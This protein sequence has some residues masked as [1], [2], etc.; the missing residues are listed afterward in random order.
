MDPRKLQFLQAIVGID[1]AAALAKA[2]ER[3]VELEAAILPRV[4]MAWLEVMSNGY[5]G[6]V[7]GQESRFAFA[8]SEKG[9][10]GHI[11]VDEG[12]HQFKDASLFHLAGCVAAALGLDHER[13]SPMA[14]SEQL[15]KLGK[16]IDLLVKSRVVQEMAKTSWNVKARRR[17]Q[18][19]PGAD[20]PLTH[21]TGR[22]KN[23]TEA[24]VNA[25]REAYARSIGLNP[26][27]SDNNDIGETTE[28]FPNAN[29]TN[30]IAYDKSFDAA[31]ETA[32][33]LMTPDD[34]SLGE[35][36]EWLSQPNF[37][38]KPE[39]Q[40]SDD[41]EEQEM[42]D[43]DY[44]EHARD[45]DEGAHHENVANQ[46]EPYIDRRAGVDPHAFQSQFRSQLKG[47][48]D[49]NLPYDDKSGSVVSN[50]PPPR[51][52]FDTAPGTRYG[53]NPKTPFANQDIR[54][55]ARSH[56]QRFDEGAKFTP[57]GYVHSPTD[58]HAAINARAK[59]AATPG[60]QWPVPAKAG[61][62]HVAANKQFNKDEMKPQKRIQLPG[63]AAAA[64]P[65]QGP[66]APTPVQ[67][68]NQKPVATPLPKLPAATKTKPQLKVTK[69]QASVRCVACGRS[70]F[71]GSTFAGCFC[72][73]ALAKSVKTTPTPE[74]FT[75]SF[76]TQWDADAIRTLLDTLQGK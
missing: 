71:V 64:R 8:K 3:A 41:D 67:P 11:V 49:E 2:A 19:A 58:V 23:L 26:I 22:P 68:A 39:Q 51:A 73:S 13:V 76:G 27:D 43:D 53:S 60:K 17:Y 74:G 59:A 54:D 45:Y 9:Y 46:M 47:V 38:N 16:S 56:V 32:H 72:F 55:E 24:Q 57:E 70:Q 65:P 14:K 34:K 12:L 35:Y 63:A 18:F 50:P 15:A 42:Y 5:D 37:V 25:R 52:G 29:G 33:A 6:E 7:P 75:L 1:G 36:Q 62:A 40:T 28:R 21:P 61:F 44:N 30:R 4:I 31:H 20:Q 66:T 48:D 10:E 69:S